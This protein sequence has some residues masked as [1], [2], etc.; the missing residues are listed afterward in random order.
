M[1]KLSGL[2]IAI[3]FLPMVGHAQ[4]ELTPEA[5]ATLIAELQTQI[6]QL[7][8]LIAQMS[9]NTQDTQTPILMGAPAPI[10][11]QDILPEDRFG[12]TLYQSDIP[13]NYL[14]QIQD[15]TVVV[16][17][18]IR[19]DVKAPLSSK[20][21]LINVEATPLDGITEFFALGRHVHQADFQT[22]SGRAIFM[23][24]TKPGTYYFRFSIPNTNLLQKLVLTVVNSEV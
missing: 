5:K 22:S 23:Q 24:F 20:N 10:P 17:K 6:Q 1:K 19:L 16:G 13:S 18:Q 8:V 4:V 3:L 7:L 11:E 14:Y 15:N 9:Y 2:L 21:T 12:I